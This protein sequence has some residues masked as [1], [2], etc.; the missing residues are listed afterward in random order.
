ME[1]AFYRAVKVI[2][3]NEGE[4][5][6]DLGGDT[7]FG[8]ARRFHP[9]EPW[10]PTR[11]RA[12]EIY[13]REYWL[14]YHCDLLPFPIDIAV[15]DSVV[16]QSAELIKDLQKIVNVEQDGTIGLQTALSI[17]KMNPWEVVALFFSRRAL[18]IQEKSREED[19]YGLL[20]RLFRT[21]RLMLLEWIN[22]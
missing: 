11:E 12:I 15:L 5:N 16:N 9:N 20:A 21:Q 1:N 8:I 13:Y 10:P 2:L 7:R 22:E 3:K 19:K 18:R 6:V 17:K 4:R 14:K